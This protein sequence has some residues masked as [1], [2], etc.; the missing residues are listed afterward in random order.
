MLTLFA[1]APA[2][3]VFKFLKADSGDTSDIGWNFGKF[4]VGKDGKVIK[5]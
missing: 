2:D 4:L 5:R 3:P 1:L